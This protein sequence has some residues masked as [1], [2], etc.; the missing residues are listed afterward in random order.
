MPADAGVFPV[1]LFR[2]PLRLFS[3]YFHISKH[4]RVI[5]E[6]YVLTTGSGHIPKNDFPGSDQWKFLVVGIVGQFWIKI[7]KNGGALIILR[8]IGVIDV[9][10]V[11]GDLVRHI[12]GVPKIMLAGIETADQA[13]AGLSTSCG[14][15]NTV[16]D[17]EFSL[18]CT[19][20]IRSQVDE[21]PSVDGGILHSEDTTAYGIDSHV[22][23]GRVADGGIGN[24]HVSIEPG[25]ST[26]VIEKVFAVVGAQD[27]PVSTVIDVVGLLHPEM[28]E[29][30]S[31]G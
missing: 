21:I 6:S 18:P 25:K 10:R 7:C 11:D 5:A 20:I 29:S 26:L 31:T 28:D 3:G 4:K 1:N 19:A 23:Q 2:M 22:P 12:T 16:T 15:E 17:N 13:G 14:H 27:S 30:F 8:M 9:K 24:P